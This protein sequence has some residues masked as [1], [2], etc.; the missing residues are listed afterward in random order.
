M[1]EVKQKKRKLASVR[2]SFT[3]RL[4]NNLGLYFVYRFII[5]KLGYENPYMALVKVT[6]RCN[7]DCRHC[8]WQK[9]QEFELSTSQLKVIL[10]QAYELG[11]QL[12]TFEGGEPTLRPDLSELIDYA[13]DKRMTVAVITN[14]LNDLK[15]YQ[16]D[17]FLVSV[18]GDKEYHE[19]I[20]GLGTFD[21]L[22]ANLE[23][24]QDKKII[25]LT[26]IS[27]ENALGITQMPK[28][29]Y[30]T[31]IWFNFLYQYQGTNVSGLSKDEVKQ[32]AGQ[33]LSLKKKYNNIVSS[34][35][36]LKDVGRKKCCYDWV[37]YSVNYDGESLVGCCVN[38]L[39]KEQ[40]ENC[41]AA[42]Y[43]EPFHALNLQPS[44]IKAIMKIVGLNFSQVFRKK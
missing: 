20:R 7:L 36:Y 39:E 21:R 23:K 6:S 35:R 10:D 9:N 4:F 19:K 5:S 22:M 38:F 30:P 33:L 44:A 27:R 25:F 8:A 29:F 28:R 13:H 16:P 40:C 2:K 3:A 26:T 11:C 43:S 12:V 24:N 41:L 17:I 42:C 31:P 34:S 14:G 15:S 18:E 37:M 32:L 1:A